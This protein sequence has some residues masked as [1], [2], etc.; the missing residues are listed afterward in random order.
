[1]AYNMKEENHLWWIQMC[2]LHTWAL[3]FL[4]AFPLSPDNFD[5]AAWI[6]KIQLFDLYVFILIVNIW[7]ATFIAF[8]LKCLFASTY[9]GQTAPSWLVCIHLLPGLNDTWQG[10][11]PELVVVHAS[12]PALRRQEDVC[13]LRP[14][15]YTKWVSGEPGIN[16]VNLS[17][18]TNKTKQI[19]KIFCMLCR[20][21]GYTSLYN[22]PI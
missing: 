22:L 17:W 19:N 9:P 21:T 16:R 12:V 3:V 13:D 11:Y 5:F 6:D 15:W 2:S 1:M 7:N 18:K 20:N 14:S 4:F 8:I 10:T